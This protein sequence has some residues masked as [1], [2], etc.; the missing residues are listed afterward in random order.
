MKR[1]TRSDILDCNDLPRSEVDCPE[2]GGAVLVRGLTLGEL[3]A[4]T[5]GTTID[6]NTAALVA[7]IVGDDGTPVFSKDDIEALKAKNSVPLMRL[8][9][10]INRLSGLAPEAEAE[11]GKLTGPEA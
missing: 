3:S 9:Q 4:L 11:L 6:I 10:T 5:S 1:L 8:V 7:C 2:W